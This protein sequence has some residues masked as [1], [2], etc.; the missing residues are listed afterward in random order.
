MNSRVFRNGTHTE[1]GKARQR[2]TDG[3]GPPIPGPVD[4]KS[5]CSQQPG[6]TLEKGEGAC[7]LLA[8]AALLG[9]QLLACL[10]TT[11]KVGYNQ[12]EQEILM[13]AGSHPVEFL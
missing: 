7:L 1:P 12:E 10:R 2:Y 9:R 3:D 5:D 6:K 8:A 13:E 11:P 4:R